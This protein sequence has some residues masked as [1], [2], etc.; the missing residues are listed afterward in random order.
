MWEFRIPGLGTEDRRRRRYRC[1]ESVEESSDAM[2]EKIYMTQRH[3][4]PV[5]ES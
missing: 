3:S 1:Q 2:M 5:K 4:S